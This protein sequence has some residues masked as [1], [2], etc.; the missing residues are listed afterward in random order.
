MACLKEEKRNL[1]NIFTVYTCD[2][3]ENFISDE[4]IVIGNNSLRIYP[5]FRRCVLDLLLEE[6][7]IKSKRLKKMLSEIE[8]Y[9]AKG[10]DILFLWVDDVDLTINYNLDF[11]SAVLDQEMDIVMI[12]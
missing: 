3:C 1:F 7:Y 5:I 2:N 6:H 12:Y 4:C 11:F 9:M 8:E 10:N